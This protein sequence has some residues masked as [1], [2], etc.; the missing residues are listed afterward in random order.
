MYFASTPTV[1]AAPNFGILGQGQVNLVRFIKV[2]LKA[3]DCSERENK[4]ILNS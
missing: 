2:L 1:I 3:R 4:L